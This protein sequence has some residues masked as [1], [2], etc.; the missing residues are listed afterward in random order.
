[1]ERHYNLAILASDLKKTFSHDVAAAT[2]GKCT[3]QCLLSLKE[4][5]LLPTE[6]RC[7]R[8]CFV[9]SQQFQEFFESE[10][11]YTLRQ[12]HREE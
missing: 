8:N 1:M 9:K 5:E 12:F 10:L 2:M 3:S 4:A 6:E 11:R 7:M